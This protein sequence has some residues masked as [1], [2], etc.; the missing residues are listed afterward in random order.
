MVASPGIIGSRRNESSLSDTLIKVAE[1][2]ELPEYVAK[3]TLASLAT[4]NGRAVTKAGAWLEGALYRIPDSGRN[5]PSPS[6]Q[7]YFEITDADYRAT[8]TE[9]TAGH[10]DYAYVAETA[11]RLPLRDAAEVKAASAWLKT[12][13]DDISFDVVEQIAGR[14]LEKAAALGVAEILLDEKMARLAGLGATT[15]Q[16]AAQLVLSRLPYAKSADT[17]VLKEWAAEIGREGFLEKEAAVNLATAID[18]IDTYLKVG[19]LRGEILPRP[20]DVLFETTLQKLAGYLEDRVASPTGAIYSKTALARVDTAIL[21]DAFGD[22]FV[23]RVSGNLGGIDTEKF[24]EELT[25]LPRPD[26]EILDRVLADC[27]IQPLAKTATP[28]DRE[29]IAE[30]ADAY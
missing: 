7:T 4:V 16:A 1:H 6:Q 24:A 14:I 21:A 10:V 17:G 5:P 22:D 3:A 9:K 13:R 19:N 23:E 30:L 18:G 29:L 25:A 26:G 27:G 11:N 12:Y 20:E 15:K 2:F 28:L 8:P